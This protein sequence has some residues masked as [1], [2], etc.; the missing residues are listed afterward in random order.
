MLTKQ[1]AF[2]VGFMLSC[3]DRGLDGAQLQNH[4][5]KAASLIKHAFPGLDGVADLAGTAVVAAPIAA[6]AG[7]GF[8][9]HEATNP[10]VDAD[11]VKVRELIEEY[12]RHTDHARKQQA[13][14]TLRPI[15]IQRAS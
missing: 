12:R 14:R 3:A 11:D 2:R 10:E 5:L 4:V 1:E 13:R 7:L 8:L 15:L 9:A 6:G